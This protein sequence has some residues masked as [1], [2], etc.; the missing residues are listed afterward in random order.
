VVRISVIHFQP[1]EWFPPALNFVRY[2][3]AQKLTRV[4]VLTTRQAG[5]TFYAELPE[6]IE[7]K[8]FDM[9]N[10]RADSRLRRALKYIQFT[11]A[12]IR[13]LWLSKPKVVVYFDPYSA[14]PGIFYKL[15]L[16][17]KVKIWIH[18]HEYFAPEWYSQGM[19]MARISH[20]LEK[21]FI[22]DRALGI[23]HTNAERV[24]LFLKDNPGVDSSKLFSFPNYPPSF[25]GQHHRHIEHCGKPTRFVAL[26]SFTLRGTYLGEFCSWVEEQG[27]AVELDIYS[28]YLDEETREFLLHLS[29]AW[30]RFH[31]EGIPYDRIPSLFQEEGFHVG[32][33]LYRCNTLNMTHNAPN[34]LFEYLVCGLDVWFPSEMTGTAVYTTDRFYPKVLPVDFQYL[35]DIDLLAT[36]SRDGHRSEHRNFDC[37]SVYS[38]W[39]AKLLELA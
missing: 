29:S 39:A 6:C 12:T 1:L 18:F 2:L 30:I 37:D 36:L 27:G 8:T 14:L 13:R 28:I 21:R 31:P 11:F 4:S 20:F 10:Y 9:S 7:L 3:A 26:G 34:K 5:Q 17:R 15:A 38:G 16:N 25:W 19:I 23:S 33:V 32:L 24:Q 22:F 35:N